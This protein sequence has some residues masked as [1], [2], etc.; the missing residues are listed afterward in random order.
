MKRIASILALVVGI[1]GATAG[2]ASAQDT[3]Q[4][5]VITQSAAAASQ[6]KAWQFGGDSATNLNVSI[7]AAV[8]FATIDQLL[9]PPAP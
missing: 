7:A 4:A 6:A 8:N 3:T 9:A 1:A 2:T 5:A